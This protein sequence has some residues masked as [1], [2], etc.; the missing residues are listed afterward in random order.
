MNTQVKIFLLLLLPACPGSI[1]FAQDNSITSVRKSAFHSAP[2]A[3]SAA[4]ALPGESVSVQL[5]KSFHRL[6]PSATEVLWNKLDDAYHVCFKA[7]GR[8]AAAVF[9]STGLLSW[10]MQEIPASSF[11]PEL[12]AT[13]RSSYSGYSLVQALAI[14]ANGNTIQ[15]VILS[16]GADYVKIKTDGEEVEVSTLC[17]AAITIP[18]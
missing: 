3:S 13:I 2:L 9:T 5:T 4:P 14:T 8:K 17:N 6:Y 11:Y 10:S 12:A 18:R 16:G 7:D 15:Q 1:V